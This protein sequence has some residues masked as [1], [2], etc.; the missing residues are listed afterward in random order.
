MGRSTTA[1]I[2]KGWPEVDRFQL[3][4]MLV[5][6]SPV[7][8][9]QLRVGSPLCYDSSRGSRMMENLLC[10][11]CS[12]LW[13]T[14][15]QLPESGSGEGQGGPAQL[16]RR[17]LPALQV[18]SCSPHLTMANLLVTWQF[19]E[20]NIVLWNSNMVLMLP[21]LALS[22]DNKTFCRSGCGMTAVNTHW[23]TPH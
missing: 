14:L 17:T 1:A 21:L 6:G 13:E 3:S 5:D 16:Q 18:T 7:R 8:W 19:W 4:R 10:K 23:V 2:G 9:K 12:L 20:R 15:E 11:G 22:S